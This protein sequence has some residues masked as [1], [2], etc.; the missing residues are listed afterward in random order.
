MV[1]IFSPFITQVLVMQERNLPT[2]GCKAVCSL[3]EGMRSTH[4]RGTWRGLSESRA[5]L[6][7]PL[8]AGSLVLAKS[9]IQAGC[10]WS[11]PRSRWRTL[12]ADHTSASSSPSG[13]S[14]PVLL[15]LVVRVFRWQETEGHSV[16]PRA[17]PYVGS[18][19]SLPVLLLLLEVSWLP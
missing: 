11:S 4:G 7:G 1:E 8:R 10:V 17:L 6:E 15:S 16:S 13:P 14:P 19:G 12:R 3:E 2:F 9:H 18:G 5:W